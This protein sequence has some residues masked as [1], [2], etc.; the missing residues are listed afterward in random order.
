[1]IDETIQGTYEK[2]AEDVARDGEDFGENLEADL[3]EF[4]QPEEISRR[5]RR[6]QNERDAETKRLA[7]GPA[8]NLLD[9]REATNNLFQGWD[10]GDDYEDEDDEDSEPLG[11]GSSAWNDFH[12]V[13]PA[14]YTQSADGKIVKT[15]DIG[16]N[17]PCPCL[18]GKKYKKC[19]G[20]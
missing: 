2:L 19:C 3:S 13:I 9:L 6:W 20:K 5:Q 11:Y 16:R 10:Y 15:L 17:D 1:M 12:S 18:S 8:R 14:G 7:A 4:Y